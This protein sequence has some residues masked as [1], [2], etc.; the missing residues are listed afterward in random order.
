MRLRKRYYTMKS[1]GM[2]QYIE[3]IKN[4]LQPTW[5]ISNGGLCK[6]PSAVLLFKFLPQLIMNRSAHR[7]YSYAQRYHQYQK[8]MTTDYKKQILGI[9]NDWII[10]RYEFYDIDP[11]DDI[12]EDDKFF[13]IYS[14]EDLLLMQ[15]GQFH[16]DIG[17]YGS[18]DF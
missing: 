2:D 13:N 11:F 6:L 4:Q 5:H 15:K 17:W 3:L 8:K 12:P 18:D 10:H 14:Q 1:I 16:L 7:Q 9:T